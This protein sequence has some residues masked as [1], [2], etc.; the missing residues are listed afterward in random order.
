MGRQFCTTYLLPCRQVRSLR[1]SVVL[2]VVAVTMLLLVVV[3]VAV[4]GES[5]QPMDEIHTM[6][7]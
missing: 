7:V 4:G 2:S 3:V 5:G 6:L 1:R